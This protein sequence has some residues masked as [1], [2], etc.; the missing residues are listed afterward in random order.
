MKKQTALFNAKKQ[1]RALNYGVLSTH[2]K[3]EQGFPF[4]S[5]S[6]FMST[7]KGNVVFYISTLAQHT[8]NITLNPK[9][10]FTVFTHN[11]SE[12]NTDPNSNARISLLGS[13]Q[14]MTKQEQT[15]QQFFMQF[16]DSEKYQQTHDFSFYQL[17]THKVRY[18][19]GFGDIHW[20]DKTTWLNSNTTW[21]D[22]QEAIIHHVNSD[23]ADV[24]HNIYQYQYQKTLHD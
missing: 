21:H 1:M 13:A 7:F 12:I 10:C 5:V 22:D 6:T 24:L 4:G 23:H 11:P 3:A 9:M 19:G 2:S 20:F 8:H 18:I 17:N 16:P 15:S 14:R